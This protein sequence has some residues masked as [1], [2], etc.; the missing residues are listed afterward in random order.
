LQIT[1][2]TTKHIK[3]QYR[4]RAKSKIVKHFHLLMT[5][6]KSF[7]AESVR[8]NLLTLAEVET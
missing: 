2:L 7:D 6:E 5:I 1:D 8:K 3:Y 4:A